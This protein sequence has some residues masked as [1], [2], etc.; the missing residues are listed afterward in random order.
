[1]QMRKCCNHPY[2]FSGVE[3]RSLD[4]HGEHVVENCGKLVLLDK[5][6]KRLYEKGHRVLIFSQVSGWVLF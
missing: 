4:P 3:D 5:L 2:L 6:L 1:M